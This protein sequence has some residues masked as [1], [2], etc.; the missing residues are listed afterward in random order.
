MRSAN[1]GRS[2]CNRHEV[3]PE[4][5]RLMLCMPTLPPYEMQPPPQRTLFQLIK[6]LTASGGESL[7][8]R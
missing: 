6:K 1:L 4:I 5:V 7:A 8:V 3:S 2:G